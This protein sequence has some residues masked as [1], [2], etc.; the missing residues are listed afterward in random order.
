MSQREETVCCETLGQGQHLAC[1]GNPERP[2][3]LEHRVGKKIKD[4]AARA[5]GA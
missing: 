5:A 1:L 4:E 3:W 2:V